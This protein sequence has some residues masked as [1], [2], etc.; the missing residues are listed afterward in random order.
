MGAGAASIENTSFSTAVSLR[1]GFLFSVCC[2]RILPRPDTA[3]DATHQSFFFLLLPFFFFS[4]ST[5]FR[6]LKASSSCLGASRPV[7]NDISARKRRSGDQNR[8]SSSLIRCLQL[9]KSFDS[10]AESEA[11]KKKK[12]KKDDRLSAWEKSTSQAT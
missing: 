10:S 7:M 2:R 5:S 6:I 1:G 12:K 9:L 4:N 3:I 8:T 11:L